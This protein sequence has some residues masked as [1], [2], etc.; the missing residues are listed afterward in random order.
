MKLKDTWTDERIAGQSSET[1][2]ILRGPH[3]YNGVVFDCNKTDHVLIRRETD[4][5]N[6]CGM[7][8]NV[9]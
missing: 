5:K 4:E 7:Q 9:Q 3:N 2:Y 8:W 6:I 1:D